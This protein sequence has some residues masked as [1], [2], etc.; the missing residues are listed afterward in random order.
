[1]LLLPLF[2]SGAGFSGTSAFEFTR[3]AVAFGPRPSGSDANKQLQAYILGQLKTC[4]CQVTEDAFTASTPKGAIAMKN[5]IAKFPG[6]TGRGIA[7]TGHFDTKLF[8][9]RKFVGASD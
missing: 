3:R 6:R 8:P 5:I 1:M 2:A 9:G 4:K 7:I